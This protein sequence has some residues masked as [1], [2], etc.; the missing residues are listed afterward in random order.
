MAEAEALRSRGAA[1]AAARAAGARGTREKAPLPLE[2]YGGSVGWIPE[3][4]PLP[5]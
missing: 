1:K 2:M 5:F 4:L 3:I